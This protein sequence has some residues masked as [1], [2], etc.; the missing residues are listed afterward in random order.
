MGW[1]RDG[2]GG[3]DGMGWVSMVRVF[4]RAP[5]QLSFLF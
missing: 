3:W 4:W 2:D 5:I 1:D